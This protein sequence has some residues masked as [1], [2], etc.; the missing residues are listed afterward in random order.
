MKYGV[1]DR[2]GNEWYIKESNVVRFFYGTIIGRL[3]VRIFSIPLFSKL[4]GLFLDS[5][6][7]KFKIKSFIK[8]NNSK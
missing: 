4:M 3:I 2:L 1:R 7:S 5:K 6:L 8:K